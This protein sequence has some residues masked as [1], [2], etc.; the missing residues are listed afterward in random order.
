MENNG[1]AYFLRKLHSL[2]GVVPLGIFMFFHLLK[3][4]AY[5]YSTTFN[6]SFDVLGTW[7]DSEPYRTIIETIFIFAPL[8]FHAVYGVYVAATSGA[9][10]ARYRYFRNWFF[11]L[12][13]VT[14]IISFAFIAWHLYGTRLQMLLCGASADAIMM[15]LIVGEPIGLACFLVGM[16]SCIF[17]FCNGLWT[18]L[19]T[20]G[21]T[22]SPRSQKVSGV[23]AV[24][25]F[26]VLA[27]IGVKTILVF[28]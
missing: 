9:N 12:Q 8:L 10:A 23:V 1:H 7:L 19:I 6:T 14:G 2:S 24:M 20:W 17:H 11:V 25:L 18:F 4:H 13:R 27:H 3:N 26:L 21:I 15:A 28:A 5:A 16:L 22:V